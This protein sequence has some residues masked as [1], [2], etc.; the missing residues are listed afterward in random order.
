MSYPINL[1]S[2][3]TGNTVSQLHRLRSKGIVIPE[4]RPYRPPL[5]SFRDLLALRTIAFLRGRT[6]A[7]RIT[8]AFQS[9]DL[10]DLSAHPS[11]YTL[12][13]DGS[14]IYVDR[15]G[16]ATDLVRSP[17]STTVFSFAE[18]TEAFKDFNDADV[19]PF[20]R[21]SRHVEVNA[22]RLGG[23]PTV[24]GTRIAYETIGNLVDNDTV[25]TEDVEYYYPSVTPEIA[26]DVLDFHR[27]VEA[28]AG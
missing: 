22:E 12:G 9:L 26:G 18:V 15:D 4:V 10:L 23:W 11:E 5:Y 17:G 1:A 25:T 28:V 27:R 13:T 19:V 16:V 20:H 24:R 8:R 14:S 3:L 6:S 2:I 7:Q 21:P